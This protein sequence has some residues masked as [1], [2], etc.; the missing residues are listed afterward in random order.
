MSVLTDGTDGFIASSDSPAK[1][2][3]VWRGVIDSNYNVLGRI[4]VVPPT[5]VF[6]EKSTKND[7]LGDPLWTDVDRE[8]AAMV[9]ASCLS[10][11]ERAGSLRV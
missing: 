4:I 2:I 8:D 3:E 6:V 5:E 10:L 1:P 9:A 11:P 7:R